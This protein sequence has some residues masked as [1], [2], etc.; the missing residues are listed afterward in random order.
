MTPY[1]PG[2]ATVTGWN[3]VRLPGGR[4]VAK[5]VSA[6]CKLYNADGH[7][8]ARDGMSAAR[9]LVDYRTP[10]ELVPSLPPDQRRAC[11]PSPPV[12]DRWPA[13]NRDSRPAVTSAV[14]EDAQAS[15][16]RRGQKRN[17]Q[18]LRNAPVQASHFFWFRYNVAQLAVSLHG[19]AG[20][21]CHDERK[22]ME[23]RLAK[24]GEGCLE[25][26][27]FRSAGDD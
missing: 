15:A 17:S 7:L 9:V 1:W 23:W 13:R 26:S 6:W 20:V 16:S 3:R 4:Y 8:L 11:D 22:T 2:P 14:L 12:T 5:G 24:L 10:A 25:K 19:G 27:S 21:G 18:P